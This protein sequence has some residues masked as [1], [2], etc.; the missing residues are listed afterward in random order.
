MFCH[1]TGCTNAA[2]PLGWFAASF[3]FAGTRRPLGVHHRTCRILAVTRQ[4]ATAPSGSACGRSGRPQCPPRASAGS[5]AWEARAPGS[6]VAVYGSI[7]PSILGPATSL[8]FKRALDVLDHGLKLLI[9][10]VL[11]R[12]AVLDLVLARN[13]QRQNLEVGGRLRPTHS[14]NS[15]LPMLPEVA[16]K[17][18]ND[19]LAQLVTR[20][21]QLVRQGCLTPLAATGW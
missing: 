3:L 5:L 9:S 6:A 16:Q 19:L 21:A 7:V 13:Q 12:I 10:Q 4:M 11:E 1:V 20:A 2:V 8:R 18:A 17:R 15:L 14:R